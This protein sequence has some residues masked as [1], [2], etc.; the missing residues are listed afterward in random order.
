VSPAPFVSITPNDFPTPV[1]PGN[2][3]FAAF[4]AAYSMA[5]YLI[6]PDEALVITGRWPECV[7]ANVCLWNRWSQMYDYVN[8][9][10]S[11]NRANTTLEPDGSFRMIL[12]HS[13]PGLPNWIDTE[14]RPLGTVF[15]RFFLPEGDIETPMAE[16]VKFDDLKA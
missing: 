2:M 12:A 4:D 11:R 15:W 3:A 5:P 9:Q 16:V 6:G 10:V 13:D 8:R 7:F 1:V 14:G